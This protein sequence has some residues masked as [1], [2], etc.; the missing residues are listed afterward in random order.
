MTTFD[1]FRRNIVNSVAEM[2][3]RG[4]GQAATLEAH[5]RRRIL[6]IGGG[7]VGLAFAASLHELAGDRVA[8]TVADG[9]WASEGRGVRWRNPAEGVNRRQQ[10]V[11]IQSLVFSRLPA[12]VR[13][14]MF[15]DGG[16]GEIWPTGR[17]SP[18]SLGYPRNVRIRDLEDRLLSLAQSQR[19]RLLPEQINATELSLRDW[20]LVVIADGA[21]SRTRDHFSAAF[22]QPDATPY[23]L[24]GRQVVDTVLGLRARSRM[25]SAS[26]VIMT[27]LQQRFLFNG[28]PDGQGL[29]YMRL[30]DEEAAE[31][32]GRA[33]GEHE[34]RPCIQSNPC[35]V[36]WGAD[37]PR[38]PFV[39][40][41]R[42]SEFVPATDPA[43]FLW[44]RALEG[45]K[46][47]GMPADTLD[48]IT[49]FPLAMTRRA[50]FSAEITPTGAQHR[51]FGALIG[52]AAGVTHFW[53]GRGLNRGLSSAY[54]LA[55]VVSR[56]DP[57]SNL[58]SADLAEFE[59]VMAQLQS[60]HQDRAWRAMVQLQAGQV[61]PVKAIIGGAITGQRA[62]RQTLLREMQIRAANLAAGLKDRLPSPPALS[63]LFE[64]FDLV[65][66]E[67]LAVIAV[68]GA[69]E[70]L[71][72]GGG[73][74]D[75]DAIL[76]VLPTTTGT[77]DLARRHACSLSLRT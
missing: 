5:A 4:P 36:T 3:A 16:Y 13:A 51:V 70:T 50:A 72:S 32:R 68:T 34:F 49:A 71:G 23:S 75:V 62:G 41:K 18:A 58:R 30:T 11:T 1:R 65:D 19:L 12:A 63:E 40:T 33:P 6:V 69:W 74:I 17:E 48:A 2:L 22:G 47:F 53:P 73:E 10:V 77:A 28:L 21:N 20:D 54:A 31:V 60:R 67:T 24:H 37:R 52:D 55:V 8:V 66:D 25:S 44:P 29:L 38:G 15:P 46:L 57:A 9:R 61:T 7:P 35:L 27:I 42:G 45:L 59:G 14:A 56:L 64:A 43:S 76:R 26:S 39:C